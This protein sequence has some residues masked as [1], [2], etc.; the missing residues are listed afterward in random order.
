MQ[1]AALQDTGS[2]PADNFV[3]NYTL[4]PRRTLGATLKDS[5]MKSKLI[6]FLSFLLG[7]S[8]CSYYVFPPKVEYRVEKEYIYKVNKNYKRSKWRKISRKETYE[9]FDK[10]GNIIER[11]WYGEHRASGSITENAN[12]SIHV[13][14]GDSWNYKKI[15]TV[16]YFQF[17]STN[18]KTTDECWKFKDNKKDYLFY[19][20]LFE[21]DSNGR[22]VKEI[23]YNKRNEVSRIQ[24]YSIIA[25][26]KIVL[27]DSVFNFSKDITQDTIITDSLGRTIENTY[28]YNGK[29]L[30]KKEFRYDHFNEIV[31]ELRYD[32]NPDELWCITEWQYDF[33]KRPIRRFWKVIGSKTEHKD[34]YIYNRKK[35]L[36]KIIHYNGEDVESYTKYKYKLF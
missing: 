35:L 8:S 12:G 28:Y 2:K 32:N 16:Y 36:K 20:T 1:R 10:K 25:E 33:Y 30:Y 6:I 26:N 27:T 15:E 19:K 22:L 5:T 17:D 34:V 24:N 3:E 4:L 21:Y 29:F 14:Y 31:T 7:F 11:G 18:K 9:R 13:V 23:E